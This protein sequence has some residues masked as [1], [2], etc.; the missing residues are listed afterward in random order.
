MNHKNIKIFAIA[1]GL[2]SLMSSLFDSVAIISFLQISQAH[3]T[4]ILFNNFVY[5]YVLLSPL[6]AIGLVISSVG[7]YQAKRWGYYLSNVSLFIF[8]GGFLLVAIGIIFPD[9]LDFSA[10]LNTGNAMVYLPHL[11]LMAYMT[12]LIAFTILVVLNLKSTRLL[13]Q[14]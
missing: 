9:L 12:A 10:N 2:V 11:G 5:S 13:F 14:S 1:V 8:L 3:L 4:E 6:S 7:L